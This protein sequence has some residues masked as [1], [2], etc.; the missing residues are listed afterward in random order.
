M[1]VIRG[2]VNGTGYEILEHIGV[3]SELENGWAMEVNIVAWGGKEGKLDVRE[4]SQDHKRMARGLT[5]VEEEGYRIAELLE[6]Y[7]TRGNKYDIDSF[8][9]H[10]PFG[11]TVLFEILDHVGIIKK[12]ENREEPWRREINIVSWNGAKPKVDI[13]EWTCTHDRMT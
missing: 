9:T 8:I 4:W 7:D 3:L 13:R 11:D 1:A 10:K 12:I 5:F 2:E 6:E